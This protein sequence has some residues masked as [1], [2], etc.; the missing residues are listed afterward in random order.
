MHKNIHSQKGFTILELIVV[1]SVLGLITTLTTDYMVNDA[2][3]KR[4]NETQKRIQQIQYALIGDS[5]RTLN[6]QPAFSGY[7]SDTGIM[8][9]YLRDLLSNGYCTDSQSLDKK[10]CQNSNAEWREVKNWKGPYLQST[11]FNEVFD[12][13]NNL[14]AKIPVFRDGWGNREVENDHLNFGWEFNSKFNN[15]FIR[16]TSYGLNGIGTKDE[17][18]SS[19]Y[20][21]ERDVIIDIP[22]SRV[23]GAEIPV[24]I[25]NNTN[26][27]NSNYCLKVT[28]SDGSEQMIGLEKNTNIPAASIYGN[29]NISGV[30]KKSTNDTCMASKQYKGIKPKMLFAHNLFQTYP[31]TFAIN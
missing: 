27:P 7:L 22:Y 4:F 10:A 26:L 6:N 3:Q 11:T 17:P 30:I 13:E 8:P 31:I 28:Y 5:S 1:V 14:I 23:K 15:E 16:I 21:Y 18:S 19:D 24:N 2:N 20:V 9:Q 29:V 25:A 12:N